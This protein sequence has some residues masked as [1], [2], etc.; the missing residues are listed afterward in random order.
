ML[1]LARR[2]P[3]P[4]ANMCP[5]HYRVLGAVTRGSAF[6]SHRDPGKQVVI[7]VPTLQRWKL[8]P[9]EGRCLG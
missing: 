6:H 7:N 1:T 3:R 5:I 4:S 8:R 9:S 2:H